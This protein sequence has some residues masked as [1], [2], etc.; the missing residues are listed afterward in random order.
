MGRGGGGGIL[1][2]PLP[3]LL[4]LLVYLSACSFQCAHCD[5]AEFGIGAAALSVSAEPKYRVGQN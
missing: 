1:A 2:P 4:V 5:E 3:P